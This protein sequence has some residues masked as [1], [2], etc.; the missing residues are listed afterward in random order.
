MNV[1][2]GLIS[3][4]AIVAYGLKSRMVVANPFTIPVL[5]DW[6][7]LFKHSLLNPP[8]FTGN[9]GPITFSATVSNPAIARVQIVENDTF[10]VLQRITGTTTIVI[11][12]RDSAGNTA[13]YQ[14]STVIVTSVSLVPQN[15]IVGEKTQSIVFGA[16]KVGKTK[17]TTF[18][19]Y[20]S[21]C[22]TFA[23][24]DIVSTHE[25]FTVT[26]T[27][28]EVI[29]LFKDTVRFTPSATGT[30]SGKLL[31]YKSIAS[32]PDT[33]EVSGIGDPTSAVEKN[34]FIPVAYQLSPNYPNPFNPS[35]IIEFGLPEEEFAR[36]TIYDLL[37]NEIETLVSERL[38][39][40]SYRVTWNAANH[41][42]GVYFY[43]L[44]AGK[45]TETRKL[46][47]LK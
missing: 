9:E 2:V 21:R 19:I 6:S 17:D 36:L 7:C 39:P 27:S 29:Y 1:A 41:A 15:T 47:L 28:G 43:R 34:Q 18:S 5:T 8:L 11:Q 22:F 31:I 30:I 10:V 16:V 25:N 26:R 24:T 3:R 35:T 40:G 46:V 42:A 44:Q 13:T 37:G 4:G 38:N 12:G 45:F 33:I 32:M 14:T 23:I 20:N